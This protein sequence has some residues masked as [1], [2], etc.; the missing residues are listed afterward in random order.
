MAAT[1]ENYVL[2]S[3]GLNVSTKTTLTDLTPSGSSNKVLVAVITAMDLTGSIPDVSSVTRDGNSFTEA[4]LLRKSWSGNDLGNGKTWVFY[5]LDADIIGGASSITVTLNSAVDALH[6]GVFELSDAFQG[7]PVDFKFINEDGV[8]GST[9]FDVNVDDTQTDSIIVSMLGMFN[10]AKPSGTTPTTVNAVN[11]TIVGTANAINYPTDVR[12]STFG[13][14][15]TTSEIFT[16]LASDF[17]TP[18]DGFSALLDYF[19]MSVEIQDSAWID[20]GAGIVPTNFCPYVSQGQVRKMVDTLTGLGHF[21]NEAIGVQ[22]DGILPTGT[23]SFTVSNGSIIL[24]KKSAV[25]HAGLPYKGTIK[26]LKQS[27]GSN[28][29]TGQTKMRRIYLATIRV[30]RSL[31]FKI[32]FSDT[33]LDTVPLGTPALPLLT[34]DLEKLPRPKWNKENQLLIVQDRPLP[35][36]IL[37]IIYKS[38]VEERG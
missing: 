20:S 16:R 27:D 12:S 30:F 8:V 25:T 15:S 2:S 6:F 23:N 32:G 21:N 14:T 17:S 10:T 19:L 33:E 9:G 29:G 24:P 26:L 38:E 11:I 22:M 31:A 3:W 1:Y 28:F 7:A 13:L 5:L 4:T 34:Q 35:L 36:F 18:A 37:A